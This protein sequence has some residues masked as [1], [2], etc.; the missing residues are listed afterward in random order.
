[1][2]ILSSSVSTTTFSRAYL[3]RAWETRSTLADNERNGF[4]IFFYLTVTGHVEATMVELMERRLM[5]T[6]SV[7]AQHRKGN[8]SWGNAKEEP[9]YPTLPIHDTL[10]SLVAH[11]VRRIDKAPLD[12]LIELFQDV[13]A[14]QLPNMLGDTHQDLKA[15][16]SLRNVFAHGRDLWLRFNQDDDNLLSLEKNPLQL[17]AQRLLAAEVLTTLQF[18]ARTHRD[19]Q[20]AFFSDAAMLYFLGKAQ[21]VENKLKGVLAFIPEKELPLM[22][23]LPDLSE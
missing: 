21:E 22:V 10:M 1:M 11:F 3:Q 20:R 7:V 9:D 15:L 23:S 14:V 19:F 16:A 6:R 12:A 2:K 4:A 8:F 5:Y 13:F 17:P 18:D